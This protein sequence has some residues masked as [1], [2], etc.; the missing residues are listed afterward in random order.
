MAEVPATLV[1]SVLLV[2]LRATTC[3]AACVEVDSETEA[4][5][6]RGFKL[7][8]ISCKRRGEV[9]ATASVAWYFKAAHDHDFYKIYDFEE[10]HGSITDERFESRLEW[11]GSTFTRDLQ[12]GSIYI[13][14]VTADDAGTYACIFYRVLFY[15][16]YTFHTHSRKIINLR[17]VPKKTR[18]W[19]SILSEV[20]MYVSIVGLQL[21]LLVEMV[22]CYR[23]I[24]AAGEEALRENAVSKYWRRNGFSHPPSEPPSP[25]RQRT[26]A[27]GG[28]GAP[29]DQ[30]TMRDAVTKEKAQY[31]LWIQS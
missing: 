11:R 21:W 17:V 8:C 14:N 26:E 3:A 19:A 18:G 27:E 9:K 31:E 15:N 10:H 29:A 28:D 23:K 7:G 20:M 24:S 13:A 1:L 16:D 2:G 5:V 30:S 6:H 22:Y 25:P 12:D 4:V